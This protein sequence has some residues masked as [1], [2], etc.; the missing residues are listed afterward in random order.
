VNRQLERIRPAKRER[1]LHQG[2][3]A[4]RSAVEKVLP[5]VR[6]A[7]ALND[8]VPLSAG[9]RH[10][11]RF[12]QKT[13]RAS[14]G[15]LFVHSFAAT[16]DRSE[17]LRAYGPDGEPL[18]QPTVPFGRSIACAAIG[19]QEPVI[20]S[21]V[22]P[23]SG[24]VDLQP[25]EQNRR[26]LLAVPLYVSSAVRVVIEL[27]DKPDGFSDDDCRVA[28]VAAEF[29]AELLRQAL[30]ERHSAAVLF[31]AVEAA[32]RA[33]DDVAK[34]LVSNVTPKADEPPPAN[35]LDELR[36]GLKTGTDLAL[37]PDATVRLA[38][39]IRVLA[40]RHGPKAVEHCTQIVESLRGLLDEA[41]GV[42]EF[43][44]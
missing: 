9:V 36:R 2:L 44:K 39:A 11:L 16:G 35:V 1:Q 20:L 6:S 12:M 15:V 41:A 28:A 34:A 32:L 26:N 27:F 8:P 14:D 3:V 30:A 43:M 4:F 10:L 40:L 22:Q 5:L 25:F 23:I 38:E 29:G 33:G 31:N 21:E 37:E 42:A 7:A 17:E 18:P 24:T 13:T 19:M